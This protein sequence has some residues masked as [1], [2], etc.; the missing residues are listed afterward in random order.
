MIDK[1]L[2]S[3]ALVGDYYSVPEWKQ[4]FI[5]E[6]SILQEG[7]PDESIEFKFFQTINPS[8]V[9][10]VSVGS[11]GAQTADLILC[12]EQLLAAKSDVTVLLD[13]GI[14]NETLK[15]HTER[16][17]QHTKALV[18]WSPDI[19]D[20]EVKP[21]DKDEVGLRP[22]VV[23]LICN[24]GFLVRCVYY[25]CVNDSLSFIEENI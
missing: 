17:Q 15:R 2:F 21:L 14:S 22:G 5:T 13:S 16:I 19:K 25:L 10:F 20:G 18:I 7:F 9:P 4:E 11:L 1:N 3:I 24:L 23:Y 6:M 8:L 12:R